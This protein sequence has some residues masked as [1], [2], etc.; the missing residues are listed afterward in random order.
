MG[1]DGLIQLP[2]LSWDTYGLSN[3]IDRICKVG[4][5]MTVKVIS[6]TCHLFYASVRELQPD[7]N[8]W[9]IKNIPRAEAIITATVLEKTEF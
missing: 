4:E 9:R 2:E 1:N 5:D 7:L 8:P 3:K 6:V